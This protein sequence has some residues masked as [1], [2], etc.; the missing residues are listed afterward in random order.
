MHKLPEKINLIR[1]SIYHCCK[2][3]NVDV[4]F[5]GNG[6]LYEILGD[7]NLLRDFTID[8]V[9]TSSITPDKLYSC[10]KERIKIN[11]EIENSPEVYHF[12]SDGY[13]VILKFENNIDIHNIDHAQKI[14]NISLDLNFYDPYNQSF[15]NPTEK[16]AEL[17]TTLKCLSEEWGANDIISFI[18]YAGTLDELEIIPEELEKL[19]NTSLSSFKESYYLTR[20][21]V[22]EQILLLP[23]PGS[24]LE[25]I[26]STFLDG[27][28]WLFSN[29]ADYMIYLNV[30]MNE[31][32]TISSVFK[33]NKL[34]L[35]DVYND[36]FLS[37]LAFKETAE[38]IHKR[39]TTTLKLLFD[40]PNLVIPKAYISKVQVM[41]DGVLGRCCLG[42]GSSGT[43][44]T[45][46]CGYPIEETD[47]SLPIFCTQP[48]EECLSQHPAFSDTDWNSIPS[49]THRAWCPDQ[50]CPPDGNID[51]VDQ[52]Q[53]K[54]PDCFGNYPCDCSTEVPPSPDYCPEGNCY[55]CVP[56]NC[57]G[58]KCCCCSSIDIVFATRSRCFDKVFYSCSMDGEGAGGC[59]DNCDPP[60]LPE[61]FPSECPQCREA[62]DFALGEGGHTCADISGH[63][64]SPPPSWWSFSGKGPCNCYDQ[65]RNNGDP[66]RCVVCEDMKCN[67][68]VNVT[69]SNCNYQ[70]SITP[71][72]S[73][74]GTP[75]LVDAVFLI[76]SS[77]S[78]GNHQ[79]N[80]KNN[81]SSLVDRL[82]STGATP[83]LALIGFGQEAFHGQPV[84]VLDFTTDVDKFKRA[85]GNLPVDG[86]E[87]PCFSAI[88]FA[89]NNLQLSGTRS[90]FFLIGDEMVWAGGPMLGLNS[91][92]QPTQPEL[93]DLCNSLDITVV[94]I[95]TPMDY[96]G[97]GN[98]TTKFDPLK[99][100]L[101]ESTGGIDADIA[102]S[103]ADIV[104]DLNLNVF[105]ASCDCLDF[106]PVPI[107]FCSGGEG[108]NGECLNPTTNIPIEICTEED[109]SDCDCNKDFVFDVCGEMVLIEPLDDTIN[110]ECCGDIGNGTG[111]CDC[112]TDVCPE[113]GC[114]G[115]CGD[116]DVCDFESLLAAQQSLWCECFELTKK[117]EGGLSFV[118]NVICGSDCVS[119]PLDCSIKV[120]DGF[121]NFDIYTKEEI[122]ASVESAWKECVTGKEDVPPSLATETCKPECD[123]LDQVIAV[124]ECGSLRNPSVAVLNNGVGLVAYESWED[125][126]SVIRISQFRTSVP[127]KI[128]PNNPANKGRLEHFSRWSSNPKVAKLYYYE[129]LPSHFMNGVEENVS[130]DTSDLVTDII[131]FKNGPLQNQCFPL[132]Q[133]TTEGP[134]GSD[135]VGNYLLFIL[136]DDYALSNPF[137]STDDVYN[138]EWFIIDRDDAGDNSSATDTGGLTGSTMV[139]PAAP[140]IPQSDFLASVTDVNE[141]LSLGVHTHNG[142]PVPVANPSIAVARNY[143]NGLENSH[144]VYVSY[145]A[146][147]DGKWNIYLRQLR[148]S[149]YSR[150]VQLQILPGEEVT[151]ESLNTSELIYRVVCVNDDC[152][153]FGN[154][155]LMSRSVVMEVLTLDRRD[156]FNQDYIGKT[157]QWSGLCSGS[158]DV[159]PKKKVYAKFTHSVVANKCAD[160]FEFNEIFY[161]WHTGDEFTIPFAPITGTSMF[162]LLRKD[163][164]N[165]VALGQT[166]I[167]VGTVEISSSQAG[168]V[169]FDDQE[170]SN[171]VTLD[172]T[173]LNILRNYKGLDRSE[174]IPITEFKTGHC[175]HPV[176]KLNSNND[177][178]VV[179]ESTETEVQQI[180]L[181]GT[182]TPTSSLPL[183]IFTPKNPD[184]SLDYFINS[185][186]FTYHEDI[187]TSGQGVNQLPDMFID[188]NNIIHLSWQSNRDNYWEIYYATL[189]NNFV[190]KRITNFASKSL[191]P[192][193]TGDDVG[194]IHIAWHDNRF[195]NWEILMAYQDGIRISPLSEQDPYM[196]SARNK[197]Y[198]YEH[199]IDTVPLTLYNNT[200]DV[201]CIN[202]L[203]VTFYEDRLLQKS[204]FDILQSD[205][206]F[207]FEVPSIQSD[208]VIYSF[209][210]SE[211]EFDN[212][213][214]ETPQGFQ[215]PLPFKNLSVSPEFD[216]SI[217][218]EIEK[219]VTTIDVEEVYISF[220]ASDIQNDPNAESQWTNWSKLSKHWDGI[221]GEVTRSINYSDLTR[222]DVSAGQDTET[223]LELVFGRYKQIRMNTYDDVLFEGS[224]TSLYIHSLSGRFCLPPGDT[225]TAY[226]D[227]T[228][229]IRVDNE[230]NQISEIPL[231]LDINKNQTYFISVSAFT[232]TNIVQFDDQMKSISC[233]TCSR[234]VSNWDSTSC[235]IYRDLANNET[236]PMFFNVRF[237]FFAD[238]LMQNL[239]AQFETFSSD[240]LKCFTV[241]G[242]TP[243][244]T[245]WSQ[246]GYEMPVGISRRLTLWPL[247]SNTTGL[248]CGVKYW[249]E[250]TICSSDG[251]DNSDGCDRLELNTPL[252]TEWICKCE[253]A[254]WDDRFE[255]APTNLRQTVKWSSSGD[256][257][258]DTRITETTSSSINNINPTIQIRNDLTGIILYESNRQDFNKDFNTCLPDDNKY[259]IYA[260]VF[261]VFPSYNMY[262][263]GSE[264]IR[265]FNEILVKSD[266]PIVQCNGS[267][268]NDSLINISESEA[269]PQF[270]Y[271]CALEGR[272]PALTLDQYNNIFT[273]FESMNDQTK[274]EEFTGNKGRNITVHTCG[275]NAQNLSFNLVETL[276]QETE[277][278]LSENIL[279]EVAP[280]IEDKITKKVINAARVRNDYVDYHITRNKKSSSVVS[281]CSII[282]EVIAASEVVA[283][284]AK[285]E[286]SPS[287]STWYPFNPE[288]GEYTMQIPWELSVESGVKTV[289]IQA[290]TYQGLNVTFDTTIIADYKSIDHSI[291][292]F[293]SSLVEPPVSSDNHTPELDDFD[294]DIDKL[295]DSS[296]SETDELPILEGI[297]IAGLRP[298][299]P[300]SES[301]TLLETTSSEYIFV[302]FIPSTSYLDQFTS[303]ELENPDNALTFDVL[304]QGQA[305]KFSLNTVY[306]SGSQ[307]FRGVIDIRLDNNGLH[308]DGLAFIIPHFKRDC[309]DAAVNLTG[310]KQY[311]PNAYNIMASPSQVEGQ[312][313]PTDIFASERDTTGQ[314]Q[315]KTTIRPTEDPYFI[316]GDP[317]YR[318]KG[319]A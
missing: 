274:C 239:V 39:L 60:V 221:I 20:E 250:S 316:F 206:P 73:C 227:L 116:V 52:G 46:A 156:V 269:N 143:S 291:K 131:V 317:N 264:S 230:G 282:L 86:G 75:S 170:I 108:A 283:I 153:E 213:K 87:E 65:S 145:Q 129:S 139:I 183:G 306:H 68:L 281:Q 91:T 6:V 48:G 106:T 148:L 217:S 271:Q 1:R 35:V 310:S 130:S 299:S 61:A 182:A 33:K 55:S 240:D 162:L 194:N 150:D 161:D 294:V 114:C 202:S 195:G 101:A 210:D 71:D 237:R 201:I 275:A 209:E 56:S 94:S 53:G 84:L 257:F 305:D 74:C 165:S 37:S 11:K 32:I 93:T 297:P 246:A 228:P 245:L 236:V 215:Y 279:Q 276:E 18:R 96:D 19:R 64:G 152:V 26:T 8:A 205:W 178:F 295:F 89:I 144:F 234:S 287:W 204:V 102:D 103:F 80:V 14:S 25:F 28:P 113:A 262:S 110:L 111:G 256:G 42:I 23:K 163:D 41:A 238:P 171:W 265:S 44:Y 77:G 51:C 243:A 288:I 308:Q 133:S 134:V 311:T 151:L 199:H 105:G 123:R 207:A 318:L 218:S 278:C 232:D 43:V 179:Y 62:C 313:I 301:S 181:A 10:L 92:G 58:P 253:S 200:S 267:S 167:V 140:D 203:L 164:D 125:N 235:S 100:Q 115:I 272:N 177:I 38:E 196:A 298:P 117:G 5:C 12:T 76:D 17:S 95:Q 45:V 273:A 289:T 136:G 78:M 225:T 90:L 69:T 302:Q 158:T 70:M 127:A 88:E 157:D 212:W 263:S 226:L 252:V 248:L 292:F 36:F 4:F 258:A 224:V 72:S 220:R 242:D 319:N 57:A 211:S 159:Y 280:V 147:E 109:N 120:P 197:N 27:A 304:Q 251:V 261:S 49:P 216:S 241:A 180:S 277:E 188:R 40:S 135:D 13:E 303:E 30:P 85:V 21:E 189:T 312:E 141:L 192:S 296:L 307:S 187:T 190:N 198:G 50:I 176:I 309:R 244:D 142:S 255:D 223:T 34:E 315:Y 128:L 166:D 122:Y 214:V 185:D 132:Y 231:P 254:R 82:A 293:K 3:L 175:T 154:D 16:D 290:A 63:G 59:V 260:S 285:N 149:E 247:L 191:K 259:R 67:G 138:I 186:D 97:G 119:A 208:R 222:Y 2:S 9:I 7:G 22:I 24:A 112:P 168:V 31:D 137:P 15:F 107:L 169:W 266:I 98:I 233:E 160:Q 29:L 174:P 284:R 83:R 124:E 173:S 118:D 270:E 121:C 104:N 184:S 47:C 79:K 99:K 155:F 81:V 268:C 286:D 249:V 146:L 54:I 172:T 193:I 126:N 66:I 219:I 314:I 300:M 229:D